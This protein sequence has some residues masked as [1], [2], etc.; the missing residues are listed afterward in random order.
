MDQI[1][2]QDAK[3]IKE[4]IKE[5]IDLLSNSNE[6]KSKGIL[7]SDLITQLKIDLE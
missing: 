2:V 5:N 3:L 1:N 6:L 4:R 7:R